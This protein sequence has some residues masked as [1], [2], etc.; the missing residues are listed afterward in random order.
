MPVTSMAVSFKAAREAQTCLRIS[1]S[2]LHVASSLDLVESVSNAA[3]VFCASEATR[4]DLGGRKLVVR[5]AIQR[6]IREEETV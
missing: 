3:G 4:V 6:Q 5:S 1:N 2:R